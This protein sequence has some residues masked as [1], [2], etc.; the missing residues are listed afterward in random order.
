MVWVVGV[1][2]VIDFLH[3]ILRDEGLGLRA[4]GVDAGTVVFVTRVMMYVVAIYLIAVHGV[5]RLCPSPSEV[6]GRI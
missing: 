1:G 3:D 6:D 4:E 5:D 2:G